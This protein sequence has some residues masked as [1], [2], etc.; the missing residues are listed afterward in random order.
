MAS[1]LRLL[2]CAGDPGRQH[3]IRRLTQLKRAQTERSQF[4]PL[5]AFVAPQARSHSIILSTRCQ[6]ELRLL[7]RRSGKLRQLSR[8][9]VILY[10]FFPPGLGSFPFGV[11][12]YL[13][14]MLRRS[15]R[16]SK[17][18]DTGEP[19][20]DRVNRTQRCFNNRFGP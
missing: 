5:H 11:Q 4:R 18:T 15:V 6:E 16:N 10:A 1:G 13:E 9:G 14:R 12:P 19:E 20:Q 2:T 3:A 7:S 8:A 17:Y